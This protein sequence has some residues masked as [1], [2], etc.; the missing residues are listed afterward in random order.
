MKR[1]K[2]TA[3]FSLTNKTVS[4][5]LQLADDLGMN[6]S[7]V[8]TQAIEYYS[9]RHGTIEHQLEGLDARL[10]LLEHQIKIIPV[11]TAPAPAP[12]PTTT[13]ELLD[14]QLAFLIEP[15]EQQVEEPQEPPTPSREVKWS[16]G[17]PFDESDREL[18]NSGACTIAA[19]ARIFLGLRN[20]GVVPDN[21]NKMV[22][23]AESQYDENAYKIL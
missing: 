12:A 4:T 23:S 11:I 14:D 7:A 3:A 22:T 5:I 13:E 21:V 17:L 18:I 9:Q 1:P 6:K 8:V 16:D 19:T 2:V 15:Q 20:G 10:S